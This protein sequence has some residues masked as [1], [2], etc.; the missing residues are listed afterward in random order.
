[1]VHGQR[2][3]D[4]ICMRSLMLYC[5]GHKVQSFRVVVLNGMGLVG[6]T[7]SGLSHMHCLE[8]TY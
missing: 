1:M 8:M 3:R 6:G 4:K 5:S 7:K 2:R